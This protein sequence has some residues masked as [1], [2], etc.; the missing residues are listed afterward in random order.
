MHGEPKIRMPLWWV[1]ASGGTQMFLD[2]CRKELMTECQRSII[3]E[4]QCHMEK[5]D[6]RASKTELWKRKCNNRFQ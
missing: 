4:P 1:I 6:Q 2:V 5:D 3:A